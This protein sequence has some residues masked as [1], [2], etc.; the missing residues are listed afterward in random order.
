MFRD[1]SFQRKKGKVA[2]IKKKY[3][4]LEIIDLLMEIVF[5]KISY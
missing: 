3:I 2:S 1:L 4:T 5:D